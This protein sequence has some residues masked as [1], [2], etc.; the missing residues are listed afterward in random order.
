MAYALRDSQLPEHGSDA[1]DTTKEQDS[2]NSIAGLNYRLIVLGGE[3]ECHKALVDALKEGG[4]PVAPVSDYHELKAVIAPGCLLLC[5][6]D[7]TDALETVVAQMQQ[8]GLWL[9]LIACVA[10]N[11]SD[12]ITAAIQAGAQAVLP[13]P[14]TPQDL[15]R[16]L[17]LSTQ[18]MLLHAAQQNAR[19][20]ARK[21][22][23]SLTPRERDVLFAMVEHGSNKAV[24]NALQLSPRTVEIYRAKTMQRLGAEHLAHA[25]WYAFAAKDGWD[26][27]GEE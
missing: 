27:A 14:F 8:E 2:L 11:A 7:D 22:I 24:A 21:K 12:H 15:S 23:A 6:I 1:S 26:S 3:K 18:G 25:V 9:P 20:T 4:W 10:D 13:W 16:V 5:K 17:S 19:I